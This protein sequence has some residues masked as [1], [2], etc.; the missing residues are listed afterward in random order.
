MRAIAMRDEEFGKER[1][2]F[3]R[4]RRALDHVGTN[5]ED[6]CEIPGI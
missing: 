5:H 4:I 1:N 3:T 2:D 6:Q